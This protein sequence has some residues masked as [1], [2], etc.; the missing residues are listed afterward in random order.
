MTPTN[1]GQL[2]SA[3]LQEG[4]RHFDTVVGGLVQHQQHHFQGQNLVRLNK[5]E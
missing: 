4:D 5:P 1:L 3:L 2:R